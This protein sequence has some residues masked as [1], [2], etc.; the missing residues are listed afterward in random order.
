MEGKIYIVTGVTGSIGGAIAQKLDELGARLILP[1]RDLLKINDFIE[2]KLNGTQHIGFQMDL[3]NIGEILG[4]SKDIIKLGLKIDG[5]V[6]AAGIAEVRPIKLTTPDFLTKVFNI[7]FNSFIE[8][9]RCFSHIS[10]RNVKLN[11][12]GISAIGAFQGNATK[13]AYCASKAAMNAAVKCLAI[14]LADKGIRIN[15]VAPGATE[16]K[17]VSDLV[18][19]PGGEQSLQ[20][21]KERQV[22]G[23]CEP[24]DIANAVI[25]LLS[26]SSRMITGTCLPVDGGKLAS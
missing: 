26:D 17:M 25:F 20:K 24:Q 3:G 21:I 11:I 2:N 10:L 16:S 13:T 19:L 22:L 7:N 8:L 18:N 1:G 12:V 6:H 23:I 14:E 9:I 4:F 5:I 15:T